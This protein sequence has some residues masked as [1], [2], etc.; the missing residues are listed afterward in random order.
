[1][2]ILNQG[3]QKESQTEEL[4]INGASIVFYSVKVLSKPL[5][6]SEIELLLNAE[7]FERVQ[8]NQGYIEKIFNLNDS[9][10]K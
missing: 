8:S 2:R 6:D 5:S 4:Q 1:M 7:G 10:K 9:T 3:D